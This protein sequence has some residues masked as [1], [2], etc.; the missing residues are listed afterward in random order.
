[1][2]GLF[3]IFSQYAFERSWTFSAFIN[4]GISMIHVEKVH[5]DCNQIAFISQMI[6]TQGTYKNLIGFKIGC[7]YITL[8][9]Y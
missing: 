7:I 8:R 6:L 4:D 5:V 1:M 2:P 3:G 9:V